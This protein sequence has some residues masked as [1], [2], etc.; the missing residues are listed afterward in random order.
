[1]TAKGVRRRYDG[2]IRRRGR[3]GFVGD[4]NS[5]ACPCG[6]WRLP[7]EAHESLERVCLLSLTFRSWGGT[8]QFTKLGDIQR[9]SHVV[10]GMVR[11]LRERVFNVHRLDVDSHIAVID[12]FE[13]PVPRACIMNSRNRRKFDGF[14]NGVSGILGRHRSRAGQN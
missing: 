5:R 1:M 2:A 14:A 13:I 11:V 10:M 7:G 4:G 12:R 3:R 8:L 6:G 9:A